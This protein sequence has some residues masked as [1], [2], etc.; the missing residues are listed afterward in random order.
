MGKAALRP[1]AR[2]HRRLGHRRSLSGRG[3]RLYGPQIEGGKLLDAALASIARQA[4]TEGEGRALLVFNPAPWVRTDLV[5]LE[6]RTLDRSQP[7]KI[8]DASGRPV[9]YQIIKDDGTDKAIFF[10]EGR[11][12]PWDSSSI[13][14]CQAPSRPEFS[15]DLVVSGLKLANSSV[16]IEIDREHRETS[17]R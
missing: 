4:N 13:A 6:A 10:A 11:S 7:F 15:T 9:P 17:S 1:G 12:R 16:E 8:V 3:H 5:T 14:W 2:Q